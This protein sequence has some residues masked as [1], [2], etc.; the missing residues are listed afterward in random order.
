[1]S[2]GIT[3]EPPAVQTDT[4]CHHELQLE[5]DRLLDFKK[6]NVREKDLTPCPACTI[7]VRFDVD[8]CPHCESNIAAH[9][10]LVRESLRRL[11]E[12]TAEI[13]R[14]HDRL[15][16]TTHEDTGPSL[17]RRLKNFFSGSQAPEPSE[18]PNPPARPLWAVEDMRT[19]DNIWEGE[20]LK[21]L[22]C[23]GPWL[24]VKTRDGRKGWV[25]ST[26]VRDR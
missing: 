15:V 22:E 6:E 23:R 2:T 1:M 14:E 7:P 16:D 5:L 25:Y 26:I 12:I 8:R 18:S 4:E 13:D 10:A 11:D 21:V 19:L 9:N 24:R 20:P 3:H 17:G